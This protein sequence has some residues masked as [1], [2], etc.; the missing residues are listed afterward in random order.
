MK[1]DVVHGIFTLVVNRHVM[2][3]LHEKR[4]V[5]KRKL[6]AASQEVEK[7]EVPDQGNNIS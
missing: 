4:E 1:S 3:D 6:P 2:R 5:A 7:W